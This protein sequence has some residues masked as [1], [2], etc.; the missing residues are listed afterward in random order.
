[1]T[2]HTSSEQF[3]ENVLNIVVVIKNKSTI[4]FSPSTIL[5]PNEYVQF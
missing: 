5:G 3:I 4:I 1:M 2:K